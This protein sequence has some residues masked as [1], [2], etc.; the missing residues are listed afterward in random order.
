MAL[1]AQLLVNGLVAGAIYGLVASGFA[2]VFYVT[3]ALHFAHG[4]IVALAAYSFYQLY[5]RMGINFWVSLLGAIILSVLLGLLVNWAIYRPLMRRKASGAVLLIASLAALI[6]GND[7]VLLLFG[8]SVKPIN[9]AAASDSH[10]IAG[11][12]ITSFQIVILAVA[13]ALFFGLWFLMQK[14]KLGK[15]MRAVSDNRE[16]AQS[17]GISPERVYLATFVIASVLAGIA[18]VMNGIDQILFPNMGTLLI[19]G[20][21]AATVVGGLGKVYSAI[22]GGFVIGIVENVAIISLPSGYKGTIIFSLLFIFLIFRP[23][24]LFGNREGQN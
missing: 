20:A 5:T 22:V 3:K 18:G 16:V 21:F 7:L 15:A 6:V 24:G 14:T 4:A 10:I 11:A 17:V 13:V 9:I 23:Q 2:L 1:F 19:V 12:A 8:S